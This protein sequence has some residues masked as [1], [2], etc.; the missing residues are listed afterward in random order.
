MV[1]LPPFGA[2][3]HDPSNPRLEKYF[4]AIIVALPEEV[5]ALYFGVELVRPCVLDYCY[6]RVH[7]S[8]NTMVHVRTK[9]S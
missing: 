1:F 5:G 7:L 9:F 3:G 6:G 4:L 2:H 8:T